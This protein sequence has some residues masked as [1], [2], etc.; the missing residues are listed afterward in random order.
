MRDAARHLAERPQPLLLQD[1]L[2]RLTQIVIGRLKPCMELRLMRRQCGVVAELPQ[3]L[4]IGACKGALLKTCDHK[5]S[6]HVLLRDQ[7]RDDERAQTLLRQPFGKRKRDLRNIGLVDQFPADAPR[8]TILI[9]GDVRVLAHPQ[10]PGQSRAFNPD[11]G[12]RQGVLH[13]I[14]EAYRDKIGR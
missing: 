12:N 7:R 10:F 13:R 3:E 14:I 4:A 9:D 11:M 5:D 2:L 8:Q 1:S 6:E